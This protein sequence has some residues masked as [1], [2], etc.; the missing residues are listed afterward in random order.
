MAVSPGKKSGYEEGSLD[1]YLRDISAYP[2]IGIDPNDPYGRI[3]A[4]IFE[5]R[6]LTYTMPIR[7]R[8]DFCVTWRMSCPSIRMRPDHGS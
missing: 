7:A 4:D 1:Q 6:N 8:S 5:R 3:M 2:L